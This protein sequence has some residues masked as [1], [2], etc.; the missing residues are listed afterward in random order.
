M[1]AGRGYRPNWRP[2]GFLAVHALAVI[3]FVASPHAE[4]LPAAIV[5]MAAFIGCALL[6]SACRPDPTAWLSPR[7]LALFLFWLQLVLMPLII[8]YHGFSPG[9]LPALPALSTINLALLLHAG[10]YA[11]FGFGLH[12]GLRRGRPCQRA[13]VTPL[14]TDSKFGPP[15]IA[16]FLA[17]GVLGLFL[18]FPTWDEYVAYLEDPGI[19]KVRDLEMS[20]FPRAASTFLRPFLTFGLVLA[21]GYWLTRSRWARSLWV[22]ATVTVALGVA[23]PF[24]NFNYNRGA[25]FGPILAL[26]A[27]FSCHVR[28]LS[29]PVLAAA[30]ALLFFVVIL[31][32]AYRAGK[33]QEADFVHHDAA[34]AAEANL[35]TV[36]DLVQVY[37]NAPQFTAFMMEKI[38]TGADLYG[39]RTLLSSLLY[40]L[41]I[42]GKP[43]RDSSGVQIY[44]QLI[45]G[46]PTIVDQVIT[47]EAEL[48][49]NFHLAGVVIG[50]AL[51]GLVFSFFHR[52]FEQSATAIETYFW[53]LMALWVVWP[54]SLPVTSQLF[55]YAFWPAYL[56]LALAWLA[57]RFLRNPARRGIFGPLRTTPLERRASVC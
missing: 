33:L 19:Q 55:I 11:A 16:L 41:P 29:L 40:P 2:D 26:A 4:Q 1:N 7:N 8:G 52:R 22:V 17:I 48:Y 35:R 12:L 27:V 42:L 3:A 10:A 47:Y 14:A 30:G 18:A 24:L 34:L 46:T 9:T 28:R 6:W 43:F 13:P 44:N 57:P 50:Y 56:Y 37:G 32:G 20:N 45:Y 21:W 15:L 49:M 51:L 38:Q 25:M 39:G 5:S 54:G 23:L 53:L 36:S 31:F